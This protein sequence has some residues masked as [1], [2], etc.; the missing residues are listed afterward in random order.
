[1]PVF[2]E[3]QTDMI[4]VDGR[5]VIVDGKEWL[6]PVDFIYYSYPEVSAVCPGRDMNHTL[7]SMLSDTTRDLEGVGKLIRQVGETRHFEAL[8]IQEGRRIS[9]VSQ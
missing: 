6:Q 1:M 7:Y 8:L 5:T 4:T 3:T 2:R 9:L